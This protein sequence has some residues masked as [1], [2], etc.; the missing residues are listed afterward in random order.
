MSQERPKRLLRLR[1][2]G[3]RMGEEV[4]EEVRFHL[5]Q[6]VERLMAEGWPRDAAE[7]EARRRFGD[8]DDV[9]MEMRRMTRRGLVRMR[10][11]EWWDGARQDVRY[12]FRQLGR[13]PVFTAVAVL[14]LGL[15]IGGATAIFSVV[16]GILFRPLPFPEP[17]EITVVWADWTARGGPDDEWLSY[18][19]YHDL[20]TVAAFEATA[21]WGGWNP[22]LT[23]HGEPEQVQGAV[24]THR[25]FSDVLGVTPAV[26]RGFT[27]ADDLPDAPVTVL[28]SHALWQRAFGGERGIVGRTITLNGAAAEVVGV[29]RPGFRPPFL[30][31]ADLWTPL[32]FDWSTAENR[33][34]GA[35]IRALARLAAG[36]S[37]AAAA[38]EA[39]ALAAR[40]EAAYP[41]RSTG[42]GYSVV[43]LQADMV[44]PA[45]AGLLT[46]LG[47]VG[48]VLLVTCVN[49]AN[50]LLARASTRRTELAVRSALG[51]RRGRVARQLLAESLVLAALGGAL[52]AAVAYAGTGLL[53][54]LAPEGT[55]RIAEVA[56]NGRVL[57][58]GAA[59]TL[60]AGVLFGLLP[61]LR[62]SAVDI[63]TTL[64]EGGRGSAGGAGGLGMRSAL[65]VAQ[66]ALALLLLVGAGLVVRSFQNLRTQDLGFEPAGVVVARVGL[67]ATRYPDAAAR[68]AFTGALDARMR[69]LPGVTAAGIGSPVP[70]SGYD[71][72]V[73]FIVEGRPVP[74]PGEGQA[75]WYR[76]A[77][78]GYFDAMGIGLVAGRGLGLED[79]E[80][81]PTAVVIN[82]TM[83]AGVFPEASPL[84]RRINVGPPEDPTWWEIVGVVEDV[85][86]FGVREGSR[87]ALYVAME[88]LPA[89]T[90][91]PVL[92][93]ELPP[94]EVVAAL[95]GAVSE[96]DPLVAVAQAGPMTDVVRGALG[97]E[98]FLSVLLS[99][100]S[101]AGLLL[102]VVG[103]YG[104]VSFSVS[105]RLREL[106]VRAALGAGGTEI[107]RL[108]LGHSMRL[109]AAGLLLG[110]VGA[111][112]L[113]RLAATLLF[114]VEATDPVTFAAMALVLGAAA[115]A[116][117]A[118][119]ALR[120]ARVDPAAVLRGE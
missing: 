45:R 85:K 75:V 105:S 31:D 54:A 2:A 93:A 7:A 111:L 103:L 72:D 36:S 114:G 18:A 113:T 60:L 47:A 4:D 49:V 51:A 109:V 56:V 41:E 91:F 88:Q 11:A 89:T 50:L 17:E 14:T 96:L 23:G 98:R 76:R 1:S 37:V 16:D 25:M 87:F 82:E 110:L 35:S 28:L 20:E 106:G 108:V 62:A 19:S 40:M 55:P 115:F 78:P 101:A 42:M 3:R 74:P 104:V 99:L 69:A 10:M 5:E 67:P 59:V 80:G 30:P 26:G 22:T 15:G 120:A 12:A 48:V 57:A 52:G 81:A 58:F 94:A 33:R 118:I 90:I 63:G 95:R 68:R 39:G 38:T 117:S 71:G 44:A 13:S 116:A 73:S 24:V 79:R 61:A 83:A 65:V 66:V 21:A 46:V 86:N 112:A 32:R 64:R 43:P 107:A 92:R 53:V 70:L 97:P 102:A 9:K 27:A 100:F 119:P 34:G 84:G 6:K 29:M 77:T 8:V